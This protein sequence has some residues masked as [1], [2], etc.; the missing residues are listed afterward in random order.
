MLSALNLQAEGPNWGTLSK[1]LKAN[2]LTKAEIT[3]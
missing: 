3:G 2:I 1:S